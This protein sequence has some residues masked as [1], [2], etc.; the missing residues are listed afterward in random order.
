M[1]RVCTTHGNKYDFEDLTLD[2]V[3]YIEHIVRIKLPNKTKDFSL[4]NV[5]FV[6]YIKD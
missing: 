2:A 5:E 3:E 6:E 1:I 4:Y